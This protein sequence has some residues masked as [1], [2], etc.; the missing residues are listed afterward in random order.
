MRD[1]SSWPAGLHSGVD[2]PGRLVADAVVAG[3]VAA[4]VSGAPSTIH[5]LVTG[6]DPLEA[7]LAA[8]SLLLGDEQRY[9][10]LLAA[11]VVTHLGLSLGWALL[12]TPVLPSRRT[13]L[14]GAVAGAGIGALDLGV[15]GRR[16][17]RIRRLPAVPQ[18]ADHVAYGAAVGVVLAW[19]RPGSR[20]GTRP[21][22]RNLWWR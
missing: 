4:V 5:A 11:A 7:S 22:P 14:A 21:Q 20:A 6:A 3:A 19:R 10:R 13:V 1:R 18:L 2:R 16:F 9:D 12:L 17:P 8:G 15:V